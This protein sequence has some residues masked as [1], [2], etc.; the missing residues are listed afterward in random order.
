LNGRK[1]VILPKMRNV[2]VDWLVQVQCKLNLLPETLHI[3]V[4]I[5]DRFL[6]LRAENVPRNQ[7][8]LL[9]IT[10]LFIAAKYEERAAPELGDFVYI[11][12]NSCSKPQIRER[13]LEIMKI[14]GFSFGFP[15]SIHFLRRYS[16]VAKLNIVSR[17]F[18]KYLI[19]L[20]L[21]E[22]QFCHLAPSKIAAAS[23]AISLVVHNDTKKDLDKLWNPTLQHYTEY[24]LNSLLDVIHELAVHVLK[25]SSSKHVNAVRKKYSDDNVS[26]VSHTKEA[27]GIVMKELAFKQSNIYKKINR[28]NLQRLV[29]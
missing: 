25:V 20:V 13:E 16:K 8:Q 9:G 6:Q 11:T 12:D 7:L 3:S 22:Y 23:V 5:I 15:L 19:E 17:N 29:E 2:L 26:G 21:T 10:S 4:G 14:L 1:G 18:A 27:T 28:K 24:N